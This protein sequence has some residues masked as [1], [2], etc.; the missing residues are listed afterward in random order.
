M[1]KGIEMKKVQ[2]FI[3]SFILL[4]LFSAKLYAQKA[5]YPV[6]F[7]LSPGFNV[8]KVKFDTTNTT[9][10]VYPQIG[11]ITSNQ[12]NKKFGLNLGAQYSYRGLIDEHVHYKIRNSYLDFQ[13]V[14]QYNLNSFLKLQAGVQYSQL[15]MSEFIMPNFIAGTSSNPIL[16]KYHSQWEVFAG[17]DLYIQ[18]NASLN[19][20][21]SFPLKSME[22]DN[23]QVTLNIFLNKETF[24]RKDTASKNIYSMKFQN[25]GY[26]ED[27]GIIYPATIS[28][29]PKFNKGQ[30][31][32]YQYL[33]D[34]IRVIPRDYRDFNSDWVDL[35]YEIKIDTLGKIT[36]L[37]LVESSSASHGTG[38]QA[39]HLSNEIIQV[40]NTMPL[41]KP[42]LINGKAAEITFYLPLRIQL[43]MNKIIIH[44]SRYMLIYK[45]RKE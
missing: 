32:L 19:F 5:L 44:N 30:I 35:L 33:E 3:I 10:V 20:K 18:K 8:S 45:N 4:F 13:F 14:P 37:D 25:Q 26:I 34:N 43:D 27:D 21:Y 36:A 15:L 39:G 31:Y 22:Y 40:I 28:S 12:L 29:P 17:V 1:K 6:R 7:A 38:H 41:W 23:F 42:A 9:N 16:G 24:K 2:V 11:F